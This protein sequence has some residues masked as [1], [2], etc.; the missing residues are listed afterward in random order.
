MDWI[1][2][3][4]KLPPE[5]QIVQTKI[6]DKDGIRNETQLIF[7]K[8]LWCVPHSP[9][10]SS[11]DSAYFA[12][13]LPCSVLVSLSAIARFAPRRAIS[14]CTRLKSARDMIGS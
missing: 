9:Q 6:D 5:N 11:S 14:S 7:Y 10:T 4:E 1:S 2:T 8:N 3:N 12:L 13:Y